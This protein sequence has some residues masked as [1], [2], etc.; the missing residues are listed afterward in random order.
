MP[1]TIDLVRLA[2]SA[3][4]AIDVERLRIDHGE[5]CGAILAGYRDGLEAGG[6][7]WILAGKHQWLH[8]MVEPGMRDAAA[9]WGKLNG[10]APAEGPVP[11]SAL[12]GIDKMMP[13]K[14]SGKY[15]IGHRV[16]GLGSL[17]RQ[18]FVAIAE[19]RG[20]FVCRE[21]KALAPSA[22]ALA[23]GAKSDEIRYQ[24]ALDIAVRAPD[25]FVRAQGNWIVRRLAP[26]CARVDLALFPKE[27]EETKLL[28]AMGWETAN[29]HLGSRQKDNL[30]ADLYKR[31]P[32][33]LH[34]DAAKM[35]EA[36]RADWNEWR[37][38]E[39]VSQVSKAGVTKVGGKARK[40]GKV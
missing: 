33:W 24:K 11:A 34:K 25:P 8:D 37:A 13:G 1:Y 18:R 5:A 10:L 23:Q 19:Y 27:R 6:M 39:G 15:K 4:L 14:V 38:T 12:R 16:A 7:P 40:A 36:T 21:A 28:H 35:V 17:G 31:A 32:N 30:L 3:H 22:W 2:A 29:L 9:F 26:D 20:G